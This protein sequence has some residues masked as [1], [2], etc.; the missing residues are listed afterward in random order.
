M[1]EI[2]SAYSRRS[3]AWRGEE[4]PWYRSGSGTCLL[5]IVVIGLGAIPCYWWATRQGKVGHEA[6]DYA[7]NSSATLLIAAGFMWVARVILSRFWHYTRIG[8]YTREMA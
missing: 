8:V 5:T 7:V 2:V 1:R 6:V 3:M 4:E